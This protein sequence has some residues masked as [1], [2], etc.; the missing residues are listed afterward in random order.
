MRKYL[1]CSDWKARL[2]ISIKR[3]ML[4]PISRPTISDMSSNG[5][6]HNCTQKGEWVKM[7]FSDVSP[8]FHLQRSSRLFSKFHGPQFST[9][10]I[11]KREPNLNWKMLFPTS[12]IL[13]SEPIFQAAFR[14]LFR[15]LWFCCL[16]VRSLPNKLREHSS[17][18]S[19][20][21]WA[22]IEISDSSSLVRRRFWRLFTT[23][24]SMEKKRAYQGELRKGDVPLGG[25]KNSSWKG[26]EKDSYQRKE[27]KLLR[28]RDFISICL[29]NGH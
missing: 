27:R 14:V 10:S 16:S 17:K 12:I 29:W 2:S 9:H 11:W 13:S 26:E 21:F 23:S 18:R 24:C 5:K 28:G 4:F 20:L 6:P 3:P 15:A 22:V 25:E 7:M 1:A 19:A 8:F